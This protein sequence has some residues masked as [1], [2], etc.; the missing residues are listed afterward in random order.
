MKYYDRT[1]ELGL[2]QDIQKRSFEE[3]SKMTV[4][5]GRR[6]I[7]KTTLGSLSMEGADSVYLF[8]SKKRKQISAQNTLRPSEMRWVNSFLKE[9]ITSRTYSHF[10]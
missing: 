4:L 6:R 5:K 7:G 8:V 3:F 10:C 2:L 9:F 1:Y